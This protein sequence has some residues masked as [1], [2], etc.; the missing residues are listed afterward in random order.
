L[1]DANK[2]ID[3]L[4]VLARDLPDGASGVL[5]R[6]VEVI[7]HL[8][9]NQIVAPQDDGHLKMVVMHLVTTLRDV[10]MALAAKAQ[11]Y[12]ATAPEQVERRCKPR[13]PECANTSNLPPN[14]PP[15]PGQAGSP[16]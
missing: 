14:W 12:P 8:L 4:S 13:G 15:Y 10:S 1:L 6:A 3:E 9:E 2:V 5:N 7:E 16:Y 11:V